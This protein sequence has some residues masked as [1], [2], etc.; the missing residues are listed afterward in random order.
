M[1]SFRES[2]QAYSLRVMSTPGA[3]GES[4]R[5]NAPDHDELSRYDWKV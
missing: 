1:A 5:E 4:R 2:I 3:S